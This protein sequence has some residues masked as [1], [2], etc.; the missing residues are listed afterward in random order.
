[1]QSFR[2]IDRLIGMIP[3]DLA[4]AL[5]Q[6]DSARGRE[7]ALRA[8]RPELLENLV[9]TSRIQSTVASNAIEGVRAPLKRVE[10]M[11][12]ASPE[13]RNRPEAEIAGYRFVLDL[14]HES[15]DDIPLTPA[16]VRQFHRDLYRFTALPGG[17][18]KTVEN[19]VTEH[20]PGQSPRERFRTVAASATPAAM[21][22][23]HERFLAE[24]DAGRHHPLLLVGAYV[25][26]FLAVHPFVDGNGR[27]ARLLTLLLLYQAGYGV[28][29]YVSLERLVSD[30]RATYYDALDKT[31]HGWHEARHRLDPWFSYLFGVIAAAYDEFEDRSRRL[32]EGRG[33]KTRAIEEFIA[34]LPSQEFTIADVRAAALGAGDSHISKVLARLRREGR[35]ASLGTGRSARW[36]RLD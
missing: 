28:G 31:G 25:F 29:R 35:I 3:G 6:I 8:Q 20:L 23:L 26:D 15:A 9:S 18:W 22:E 19:A 32:G 10:A 34:T 30:S 5:G 16:V 33:A 36:R 17:D 7:Q 1:M 21:D 12:G 24:R 27:M 14:I 4:R 2:K 13:P 11:V